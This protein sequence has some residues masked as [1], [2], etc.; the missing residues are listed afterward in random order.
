M[1]EYDKLQSS[2]HTVAGTI[3]DTATTE[4]DPLSGVQNT[5]TQNTEVDQEETSSDQQP[6]LGVQSQPSQPTTKESASS[7]G[8]ARPKTR[9]TPPESTG[10]KL[11]R[12]AFKSQLHGLCRRP[13]KDRAY[14]CQVCDVSKRSMESLNEHHL[15]RHNLQMCGVCGKVFKLAT[16]LTHHMYSHYERKHH[17]DQC[18]FHSHFKSELDSH[19]ITHHS[20]PSHQ[21]MYPKCGRW[22]MGKGD[23]ALHV[24]THKST[25]L[26]CNKCDFSTKILK[27][28]KEHKKS[29]EK[30][31]PYEC[32]LCGKHFR[33]RSGVKNHK[34]KEH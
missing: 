20:T 16:K 27:Y 12:G 29:H 18:E 1:E 26:Y 32:S 11:T 24:E 33:W 22:F 2:N 6:L 19:R 30:I 15:R 31:L 14:K 25:W 13:P 5:E 23:L 21:C 17:C 3:P 8:G 7:K 34:E 4:P 10:R 28:L 9:K